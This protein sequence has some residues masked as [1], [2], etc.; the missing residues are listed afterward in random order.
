MKF[1]SYL[2]LQEKYNT[3]FENIF[4]KHYNKGYFGNIPK[5]EIKE[6]QYKWF[7]RLVH[8]ICENKHEDIIPFITNHNNK[9]TRKYFSKITGND[10]NLKG[11]K[12]IIDL[13]NKD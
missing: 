11:K 2:K 3:I 6:T 5:E 13:L 12:E 7:C 10:I 4:E 9:I 1:S 8:S